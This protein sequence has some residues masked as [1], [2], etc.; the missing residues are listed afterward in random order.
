MT[1]LAQT[2]HTTCIWPGFQQQSISQ[3]Q[4]RKPHMTWSLQ[5]TNCIGKIHGSVLRVG[6]CESACVNY[7]LASV[8]FASVEN[9]ERRKTDVIVTFNCWSKTFHHFTTEIETSQSYSHSFCM[10][11]TKRWEWTLYFLSQCLVKDSLAFCCHKL[12][13]E[14]IDPNRILW[15]C[16]S[17]HFLESVY[18]WGIPR[19]GGVSNVW[20]ARS[21]SHTF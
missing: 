12:R 20:G 18:S 16:G 9:T 15:Y 4:R 7:L 13:T 19:G 2:R 5:K 21:C 14:S 10:T 3:S 11:I 8:V 1:V 17:R 6:V